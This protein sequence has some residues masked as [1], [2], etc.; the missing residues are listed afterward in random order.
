M[1]IRLRSKK[2]VG[3]QTASPIAEAR[4]P[5][6]VAGATAVAARA[7]SQRQF[8]KLVAAAVGLAGAGQLAVEPRSAQAAYI[9]GPP[10]TID[11]SLTVQGN[12]TLQGGLL[13]LTNGASNLVKFNNQGVAVPSQSQGWKL[14]LYGDSPNSYGFGIEDYHLWSHSQSGH[15]W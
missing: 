3:K 10:D 2:T 12:L 5:A 8:L 4:A 1:R 15:R 7:V 9:T 14:R 6:G 11:T 13:W